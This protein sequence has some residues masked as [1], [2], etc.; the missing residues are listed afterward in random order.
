MATP[1]CSVKNLRVKYGL[2][3]PV[4]DVSFEIEPG[5]GLALL[6]MNGAGKSSI[7]RTLL[8]IMAV[9]TGQVSVLGAVDVRS[10]LGEI[11]Y[12]PEDA[13]PPEFLTVAEYMGF[14]ARVRIAAPEERKSAVDDVLRVFELP[15]ERRII[16]L[17]KGMTRRVVLAQSFLGNPRFVV[18][19]EPL[20]GLDPIMIAGLR[21]RINRFREQGGAVLYSSHLLT[22]A[23]SCCSH[24]VILNNGR[25]AEAGK[26][27]G[28]VSK[29]GSLEN[30]FRKLVSPS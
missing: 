22:E 26:I 20:N 1:V 18:L 9:R 8:G 5:E 2:R 29:Y 13:A 19:D 15:G 6:G 4:E 7:V 27:T 24:A 3:V 21:E 23:E 10:R 30:A 17:S 11:G 16:E 25:V 14:L 28:F 12:C